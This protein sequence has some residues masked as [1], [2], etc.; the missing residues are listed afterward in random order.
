MYN[1]LCFQ[2]LFVFLKCQP[3]QSLLIINRENYKTLYYMC[4]VELIYVPKTT[5]NTHEQSS[6]IEKV[7]LQYSIHK[8]ANHMYI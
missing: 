4:T 5:H 7:D 1:H 2:T 8:K 6:C 3:L